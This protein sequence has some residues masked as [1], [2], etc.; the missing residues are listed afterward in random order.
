[1]DERIQSEDE[2]YVLY[3]L[4]DDQ[5]TVEGEI[6]C[7]T[8][9]LALIDRINQDDAKNGGGGRHDEIPKTSKVDEMSGMPMPLLESQCHNALAAV[10]GDS[11]KRS[12]EVL[13]HLRSA[14]AAWG[15]NVAA[16]FNLAEHHRESGD[17]D[18]AVRGYTT[19]VELGGELSQLVEND[20]DDDDGEEE[21]EEEEEEEGSS[22]DVES[23]ETRP[24]LPQKRQQKHHHH[25]QQQTRGREEE[26]A[27]LSTYYGGWW[28]D[29]LLTGQLEASQSA[30]YV[31][32][33]VLHLRQRDHDNDGDGDDFEAAVKPLKELGFKW[34]LS[35]TVWRAAAG[36][37]RV[38]VGAVNEEE[39]MEKKEKK[40][41][42]A[43]SSSSSS[44]AAEEPVVQMWTGA[45][46]SSG[47]DGGGDGDNDN[48]NDGAAM[49][50]SVLRDTF[51]P[52]APFWQETDYGERGYY[53]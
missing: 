41:K 9:A 28:G 50:G 33:L 19:C 40:K 39:M 13:R 37:G 44:T 21:E 2:P 16:V 53:S 25:Q 3:R 52:G 10:L 17:L 29:A 31:R 34:R 30:K 6:R 48:D 22:N 43:A 36:K 38:G 23:Q 14:V 49:V 32:A 35:P 8:K 26:G 42:S 27:E 15:G 4:V 45:V 47:D 1:M 12:A 20:D 46:P 7:L 5:D 18:E 24:V 11:P 51:K